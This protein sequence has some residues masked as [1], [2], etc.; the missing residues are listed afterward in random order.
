M[1]DSLPVIGSGVDCI[2]TRLLYVREEIGRIVGFCNFVTSVM[3]LDL[4]LSTVGCHG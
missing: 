4:L 2:I 3:F 1:I